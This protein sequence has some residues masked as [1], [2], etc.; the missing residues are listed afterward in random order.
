MNLNKLL[1]EILGQATGLPVEQDEYD[2]KKTE[3]ILFVYTDEQPTAHAD[4]RPQ[5]DIAYMQIQLITP[6]KFN[7][8]ALKKIIRNTL[9]DNDF[10]V[11]NISSFL[12]DEIQGTEKVRQT[13]FDTQYCEY[14]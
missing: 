5:A 7:Y 6:K 2:G 14:R 13:V 12:G 1:K 10:I 3:Y 8:M 9:E 11:T 4:N